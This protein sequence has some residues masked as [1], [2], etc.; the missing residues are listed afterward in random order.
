[1]GDQRNYVPLKYLARHI[2]VGIVITPAKWYVE[3]GDGIPA[4]RGVNVKPGRIVR[5][6]LVSI[7]REGHAEN[8]KSRLSAGDVVVVRT[9]QAGAAAVVPQDLDGANCIDLILV[10]PGS[11]LDPKYL[12]LVLNSAYAQAHV[13]QEPVGSIQAHFNVGAM[14]QIPIPALPV[15]KQRALAFKA[16]SEL[17]KLDTL[18]GRLDHQISLLAERRQSLIMD[19]VT[20][21][22]DVVTAC[23]QAPA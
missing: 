16:S 13:A 19:A 10:R 2:T 6:D 20:G 15:E 7:S 14:R 9:G 17:D 11:Q 22:L 21:Q 3:E 4:L 1:G 18:V 23:Q 12:E 8:K 5:D